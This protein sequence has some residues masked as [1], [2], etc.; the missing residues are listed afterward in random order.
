MC[1]VIYL[2]NQLIGFLP[3]SFKYVLVAEKGFEPKNP[4]W[5]DKGDGCTD[6]NIRCLLLS[7]F[8]DND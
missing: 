2:I 8:S 6:V 3:F 1:S 4:L 5:A 7:I